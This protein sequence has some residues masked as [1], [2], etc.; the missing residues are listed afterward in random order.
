MDGSVA[1]HEQFGL[2]EDADHD[3]EVGLVYFVLD[4]LA[5]KDILF[6]G[7]LDVKIGRLA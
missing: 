2:A 3:V 4:E 6:G 7:D 5:D 1:L